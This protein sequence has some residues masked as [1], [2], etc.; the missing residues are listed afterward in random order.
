MLPGPQDLIA[1][2]VL[3]LAGST[4]CV[5][6]CGPLVAGL[7]VAGG[8]LPGARKRDL[9][10]Q[11][12]RLISYLAVGGVTG[13]LGATVNGLAL[14]AGLPAIAALLGG[15]LMIAVGLG[16][17][18]PERLRPG[19]ALFARLSTLISKLMSRRGLETAFG[20]GAFTALFPCGLLYAAYGRAAATAHPVAGALFMAVFALCSAP[21]LML[22][23]TLVQRLNIA[24]DRLQ[25]SATVAILALGL[26]SSGLAVRD[27]IRVR[28]AVA[29]REAEARRAPTSSPR[30]DR[31]P[32]RDVPADA[33]EDAPEDATAAP[34]P[35]CPHCLEDEG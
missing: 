19:Q 4:H 18:L 6:M 7:S 30:T 15:L 26:I 20:L 31:A 5:A 13:L 22:V 32:A 12:G 21:A 27:L 11:T 16:R 24:R 33:P 1:A 34:E 17:L 8:D 9:A 28:A 10:W 2:A 23:S 14:K 3:G 29:R 35:I 25:T